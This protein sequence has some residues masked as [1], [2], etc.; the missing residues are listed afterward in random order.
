MLNL[1]NTAQS[2]NWLIIRKCATSIVASAHFRRH[3]HWNSVIR[4]PDCVPW[5]GWRVKFCS[6]DFRGVTRCGGEQLF[7]ALALFVINTVGADRRNLW[8][9]TNTVTNQVT[10]TGWY[11][12][13][14]WI[15][16]LPLMVYKPA[17]FPPEICTYWCDSTRW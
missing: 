10:V 5:S 14:P 6:L 1:H 3:T 4:T 16:D 12:F 9:K 17:L 11:F 2:C 13:R 8:R 15:V 7:L